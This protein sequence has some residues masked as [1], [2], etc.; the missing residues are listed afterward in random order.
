MEFILG[1]QATDMRVFG[2]M[3]RK[4]EMECSVLQKVEISMKD[5][6]NQINEMDMENSVGLMYV[7]IY[8]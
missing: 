6:T 5:I 8:V 3:E 2:K 4:K 7:M 1:T